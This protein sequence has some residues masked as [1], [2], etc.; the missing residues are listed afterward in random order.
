MA[1]ALE[2][3]QTLQTIDLSENNIGDWPRNSRY[4]PQ[5]IQVVWSNWQYPLGLH[6]YA[7]PTTR[8]VAII[9]HPFAVL[10]VTSSEPTGLPH[11]FYWRTAAFLHYLVSLRSS[12]IA[13]LAHSQAFDCRKTR[14]TLNWNCPKETTHPSLL[15]LL[16]TV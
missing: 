8:P 3:N 4:Y 2:K 7:S 14:A 16:Y 12:H 15:F 6:A 9:V 5:Y 1:A 10:S 11:L 13:S